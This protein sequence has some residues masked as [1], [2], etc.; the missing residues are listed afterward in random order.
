[1]GCPPLDNSLK[2]REAIGQCGR[3]GLQDQ[4]RLDFVEILVL[5][6]WDSVEANPR[7]DT[8]LAEF[9]AAP[10]PDN[11]IRLLRD[12]F[13]KCHYPVLG[14]TLI[15]AIG[16]NVYAAGNL[17]KLRN[18]RNSGDQRIV[19][20][21]KEHL[22]PFR[23]AL[24]PASG[25]DQTGFQRGDKLLGSPIGIDHCAQHPNHVEDPRDASL[26]EDMDIE[27]PTNEIRGNV[28]LEIGERQNEVGFQCEDFGDIR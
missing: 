13:L 14:C 28:G 7:R 20:L 27:P 12:N 9:L 22:R 11:Q 18:P 3:P 8:L 19:P 10:R 26:I 5:H 2:L 1:M 6:G 17:E 16:E 21:L 15:S 25:L 23:Q 24:C 4:G